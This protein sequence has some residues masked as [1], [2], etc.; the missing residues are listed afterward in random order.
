MCKNCGRTFKPEALV[1]HIKACTE[2]K[3]FNKLEEGD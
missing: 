3:P 1:H 2:G